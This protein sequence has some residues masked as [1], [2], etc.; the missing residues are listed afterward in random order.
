MKS[1]FNFSLYIELKICFCKV[2]N[3][4]L[5]IL[6]LDTSKN[7]HDGGECVH[8]INKRIYQVGTQLFLF[9]LHFME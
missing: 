6:L 4:K 1:V 8:V 2:L 7:E 9:A 5:V 3:R